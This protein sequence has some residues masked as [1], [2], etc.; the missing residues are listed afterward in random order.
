MRRLLGELLRERHLLIAD[1]TRRLAKTEI[2]FP[3]PVIDR[4]R[5]ERWEQ[6]GSPTVLERAHRQV[7]K[8]L[9]TYKASHLPADTQ[10]ELVQR[11]ESKGR[12]HGLK[13]LPPR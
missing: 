1:H 4:A 9:D 2:S 7:N 11:M 6:E 10:R 13:H 12:R 3:G 5:C 8:L